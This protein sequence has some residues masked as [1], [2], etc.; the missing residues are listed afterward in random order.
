M[1]FCVVADRVVVTSKH[2]DDEQYVWESDSES[3]SVVKDPRG[4]TLARGT[5]VR[6]IMLVVMFLQF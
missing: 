2:N 3:F 5:T 1:F 4:N 6:Y